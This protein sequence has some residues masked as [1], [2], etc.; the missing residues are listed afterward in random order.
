[1]GKEIFNEKDWED[2]IGGNEEVRKKIMKVLE[3]IERSKEMVA[4]SVK[5]MNRRTGL[6]YCWNELSKMYDEGVVD[7]KRFGKKWGYRLAQKI[8]SEEEKEEK[9]RR[10]MKSIEK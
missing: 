9:I 6:K 3:V 5:E 4:V 7:R 2:G 1:M 10:G 8:E